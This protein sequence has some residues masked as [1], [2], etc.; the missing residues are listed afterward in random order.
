MV[1]EAGTRSYEVE[2]SEGMYRRNR[3]ALIPIPETQ[4]NDKT[5]VSV[6]RY[7]M[8]RLNQP[9]VGAI[10]SLI[11]QID[12]I[13]DETFDCVRKYLQRGDVVLVNIC[14]ITYY[15]CNAYSYVFT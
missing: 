5:R 8:I 6:R 1:Q 14:C 11:L 7:P 9:Y 12:S 10:V 13:Q 15:F 3:R 4:P 2:T